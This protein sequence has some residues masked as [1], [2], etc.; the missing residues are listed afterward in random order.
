MLIAVPPFPYLATHMQSITPYGIDIHFRDMSDDDYTHIHFD[1][2]ARRIDSNQLYIADS[3][4]YICYVTAVEDSVERAQD[5]VYNI[6]HK[7]IL[8]RMIYRNDIG[9]DFDEFQLDKLKE[10]GYITSL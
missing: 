8:P 2:V 10:W 1:G 7:I 9:S 6:I 5:K 4:G 3:K